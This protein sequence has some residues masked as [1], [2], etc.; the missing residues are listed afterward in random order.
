M[1]PSTKSNSE[2]GLVLSFP[3]LIQL[4]AVEYPVSVDSGVVLMG[5][6]TALIP[7]RR[8]DVQTIEWHVEVAPHDNQLRTSELVA[9]KG[10]WMQTQ[11]MNE[12]QS[13]RN[14]LGWCP[15]AEVAWEVYKQQQR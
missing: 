3:D 2:W 10:L 15:N 4:T 6:S 13:E 12:L 8:K 5:Y 11:D 14:L 1:E 7:V 9:T